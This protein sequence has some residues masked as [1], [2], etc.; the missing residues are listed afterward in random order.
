MK[1]KDLSLGKKLG[2]GFGA[3]IIIAIGIAFFAVFGIGDIVFN[4]SQVIDGNKLRG[5]MIEAEVAHLNWAGKVS[6]FLTDESINELDVQMDDHKCAFGQWLYGEERKE[7]EILLPSLARYL[8]EIEGYHAD[9]HRSAK[10][11]Q[12]HYK[13]A[14]ASLPKFLAEKEIDH[15][16]FIVDVQKTFVENRTTFDVQTDH[17]KCALGNWLYGEGAR[18]AVKM[19]PGM[20]PLIEAI[21]RPHEKL[22]SSII[23]LK[24]TWKQS[25]PQALAE[26]KQL[27]NDLTLPALEQTQEAFATL[28]EKAAQNLDGQTE[29]NQIYGHK[30]T[31]A[32]H[33]VQETLGTIKGEIDRGVMTDVAMLNAAAR[34]KKIT[35]I[36]AVIASIIGIAMAIFLASNIK[37]PIIKA[38]NF[39]RLVAKGDVSKTLDIDQKDEIGQLASDLNL[40]VKGMDEKSRIATEIAGGNLTVEPRAA[41]DDDSLGNALIAM[42]SSLNDILGQVSTAVE[43]VA[44]GSQQVSESS[45]SVSQGATEQASSLEQITSSMNEMGSQTKQNAE[46]ANQAN[47][48]ANEARAAAEKGN[49]QMQDMVTAMGEINESGKNISKIIK[50]IDEIAFQTNL[51]ALN[52]AVEAARAGKHGK[53]FAVVAEEVRNLAGR[54]AK[55]AKETAELIEG[56]VKKTENGADIAH[57]TAE[58]LNEILTGVTK[59]SDLVGEIAAASN[60]QAQGIAQVNQGLGQIDQVTQQATANAEEGA[61]AAEELSSQA[62]QLKALL[63]RFT[64]KNQHHQVYAQHINN[65]NNN[66]SYNNSHNYVNSNTSALPPRNNRQIAHAH[67]T[68]SNQMGVVKVDPKKVIPLDDTEFGKY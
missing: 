49:A 40:A 52:A 38:I 23:E 7:A 46:N 13:A 33:K 2:F 56:S 45:Q 19:D 36:I 24:R 5:D 44:S 57:K 22:H 51:L 50:V 39:S 3:L 20:G 1:W 43:Q 42:V 54:S 17:H 25:N 41:S 6:E 66:R 31:P 14:D 63:Q 10:D 27:F 65:Y 30:T 53:G 15:L 58:A 55:A 35:I 37:G 11:I 62:A 9:L 21:K 67:N 60:D 61:S 16:K 47:Q 8:S 26:T 28:K 12:N 32:L 29:A 34:T 18:N 48:L 64:L 59:A 4:A 68:R